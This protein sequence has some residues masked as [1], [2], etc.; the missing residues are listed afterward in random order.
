MFR[1]DDEQ[2]E[3]KKI[4]TIELEEGVSITKWLKGKEWIPRLYN[5][6][7]EAIT[8]II[9]GGVE[10]SSIANVISTE[11][12]ELLGYEVGITLRTEII[13]TKNNIMSHIE[14]A[15]DY[16]LEQE[17]YM[18]CA[19]LRDMTKIYEDEF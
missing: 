17:Y 13:L 9:H 6:L 15:M 14:K 10:K 12:R 11:Y 8:E 7:M 4:P 3:S 1:T 2:T 5:E 18:D 19:K 16:A